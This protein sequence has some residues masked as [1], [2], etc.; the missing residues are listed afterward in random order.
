MTENIRGEAECR[1]GD[2]LLMFRLSMKAS[3]RIKKKF[4]MPLHKLLS[5]SDKVLDPD[6]LVPLF[7]IGLE[8]GGNEVPESELYELM[9][10]AHLQDY[11]Q[12]LIDAVGMKGKVSEE[13]HKEEDK[14]SPL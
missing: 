9:D 7:A 8:A 2:R 4:G 11:Q 5:D 3:S 12:V 1:I 10:M 6:V 14:D 13:V